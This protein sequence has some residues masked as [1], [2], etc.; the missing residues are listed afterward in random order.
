[1]HE[2]ILQFDNNKRLNRANAGQDQVLMI[3]EQYKCLDEHGVL[4]I[5]STPEAQ[6][7][8]GSK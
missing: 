4:N 3:E 5:S 8:G 1:M 6:F 2:S 7:T